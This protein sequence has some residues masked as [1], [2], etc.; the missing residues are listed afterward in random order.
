MTDDPLVEEV[1]KAGQAYIDSFGG[2]LAAIVADL[3]RR[4]GEARRAGRKVVA[5][6]PRR[7]EPSAQPTRS[8]GVV[9]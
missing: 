5:M 3:Q 4:T 7:L 6:S 9:E 2:D 1:R 8:G